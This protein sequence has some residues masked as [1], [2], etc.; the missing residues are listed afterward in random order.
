[1][2]DRS[3]SWRNVWD[4]Q[5]TSTTGLCELIA[6]GRLTSASEGASEGV[7]APH[8]ADATSDLDGELRVEAG[9]GVAARELIGGL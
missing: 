8:G 3:T 5:D 6:E 7:G 2:T 9:G 4:I 1:M